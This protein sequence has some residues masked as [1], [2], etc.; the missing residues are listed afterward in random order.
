MNSLDELQIRPGK[1]NNAIC[2]LDTTTNRE[3]QVP[4]FSLLKFKKLFPD[5]AFTYNLGTLFSVQP[6]R[7]VECVYVPN[8]DVLVGIAISGALTLPY[9]E[10]LVNQVYN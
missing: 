10:M 4:V 2:I 8:H 6:D 9:W 7:I 5:C 1:T 3:L